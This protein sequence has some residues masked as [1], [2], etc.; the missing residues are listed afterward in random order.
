MLKY[1]IQ[2][3]LNLNPALT[4]YLGL[5]FIYW[6]VFIFIFLL[7]F[8]L[9]VIKELPGNG[10]IIHWDAGWYQSISASGYAH[11]WYESSN[12]AF[13]P[14]FPYFW[15]LLHVDAV[16]ISIINYLLALSGLYLL[17]VNFNPK[18]QEV[19]VYLSIPSCIFFFLPF[20]EALFFFCASL[21]L[22]GLKK[23]KF[24]LIF[25]GLLLSSLTRATAVFFIPSII[26]MELFFARSLINKLAWKKIILYSLTSLLGL[27]IV[28]MIQY[29]ATGEWFAFVGQ[30][31]KYWHHRF[32]FPGIPFVTY[33]GSSSILWLDGFALL[34][35]FIAALILIING[36][37][38]FTKKQILNSDNR[39]FWFS[40]VY[41]FM[42]SVYCL[43]FDAKNFEGS[44]DLCSLHRYLFATPFFF[45]FFLGLLRNFEL[46]TKHILI[47]FSVMLLVWILLGF[48]RPLAFLSG[49]FQSQH[50]TTIFFL[51]LTAYAFLYFFTKSNRF[52]KYSAALLFGINILLSVI[53]L[54]YYLESKWV[55]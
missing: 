27:F 5:S 11:N 13:F 29:C 25:I 49:T 8:F 9:G 38:F 33:G 41:A 16:F 42:V 18:K 50:K 15:K 43:F 39:A 1:K 54:S 20:T 46:N 53:V 4:G 47:L 24:K 55:A 30:Q 28:V 2:K 23:D 31:V 48:G 14:L 44:T 17:V 36:F 12:T 10:N 3:I 7:L 40:S 22:V 6:A 45:I 19:L 21:F 51:F 37:K 32:S 35:G 34:F 26:V 52:G